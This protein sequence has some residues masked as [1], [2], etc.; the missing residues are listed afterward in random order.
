[1]ATTQFE[2]APGTIDLGVGHPGADLLPA[3][4]LRRAAEQRLSDG[5]PSLLQYGHEQGDGRFR[6]ALAGFLAAEYRLPVDPATLFVTN[7][8]SQALDM[9]C[10]LLTQPG[11][12][13]VVE[14]PTYFLASGIFRDYHLRV[15][16]VPCDGEGMQVERLAEVLHTVRPAFV[17]TIPVFQNPTGRTLSPA[18]REA[19]LALSRE[20]GFFLVAD[21]VYQLLHYHERPPAPFAAHVDETTVI[22]LGS[23]S[24]IC[25]PGLRLGWVQAAP[26]IIQR[27]CAGGMVES[28]G[29]L[30]PFTGALVQVALENGDETAYVAMLRTV[31][32]ARSQ[33]LT[34]ALQAD[35]GDLLDYAPVSG[36]YFLWATLPEGCDTTRLLATAAREQVGYRAGAKFG[37]QAE[38]IAGLLQ[39]ALRLCFAYYNEAELAEGVRRLR[40]AVAAEFRR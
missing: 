32:R 34:A 7:G 37:T 36:G 17:Y 20:Y 13:V 15:V 27:F 29:G 1:M 19:L 23:F 4:M 40:R 10:R 18:R 2:V 25:G 9:V 14:E 22:S 16:S 38:P 24:K 5:D 3:A 39:R 6:T 35:F 21:E 28:G 33:A 12:T 30:N 8:V 11:D 31:Y 26:G